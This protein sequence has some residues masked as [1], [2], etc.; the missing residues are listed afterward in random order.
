MTATIQISDVKPLP[1]APPREYCSEARGYVD[2]DPRLHFLHSLTDTKKDWKTAQVTQSLFHRVD[3]IS[4]GQAF[5]RNYLGYLEK[6]WQDH[7][8]AV[9]SPDILWYGLLCE[10]TQIVKANADQYRNLF[11]TSAEKEEILI[12][13]PELVVMPL[14]QLVVE[15][16]KAVPMNSDLF[17]PEFST[18][19]DRSKSAAIAAFC[20]MCSPYYNYGMFLCGIPAIDVRGTDEDWGKL[21]ESWKTLKPVFQSFQSFFAKVEKALEGIILD[22]NNPDFWK[23]MFYLEECGSGS[24]VEVTGWI[25]DL[26]LETPQVRYVQNYSSNI[27]VV[28]YKQYNTGKKYEMH[29]GLFFSK[30]VDG[31]LVPE[32][33]KVV[34]EKIE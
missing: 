29:Q 6:C 4:E 24:Q 15:L 22:A 12:E 25:N 10:L 21:Y 7:Q 5:H 9:V 3:D 26:F 11:T 18:S 34:L 13:T 32:F 30:L 1:L 23:K 17:M 8:V 28:P 33:G 14:E 2:R 20:D 27:S 19:T 31:V 16:K